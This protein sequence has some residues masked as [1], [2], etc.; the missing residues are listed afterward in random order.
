MDKKRFQKLVAG[1]GIIG[2]GWDGTGREGGGLRFRKSGTWVR[3]L[4]Q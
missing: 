4:V 2:G 3:L 1:S